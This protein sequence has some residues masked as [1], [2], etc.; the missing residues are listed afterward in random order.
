MNI[1]GVKL[2]LWLQD[3]LHCLLTYYVYGKAF[4]LTLIET[5]GEYLHINKE[6]FIFSYLF[7]KLRMLTY[8]YTY[9]HIVA[10]ESA[11]SI[12]TSFKVCPIFLDFSPFSKN[13]SFQIKNFRTINIISLKLSNVTIEKIEQ[14]QI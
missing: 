12:K 1:Y 7:K 10:F 2:S 6:G 5:K 9:I 3:F 14:F 13:S 11:D 8:I 4:E